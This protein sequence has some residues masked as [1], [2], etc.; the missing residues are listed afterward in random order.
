MVVIS[1][2]L[3]VGLASAQT[4]ITFVGWGNESRYHELFDADFKAFP[5]LGEKYEMRYVMAPQDTDAVAKL[6]LAL[7]SGVDIPDI[8][9]F[10][11]SRTIEFLQQGGIFADVT[12]YIE[13]YKDNVI[14]EVLKLVSYKDRYYGFPTQIKTKLWF[15]RKDLCD[16]A[17][18]D[19]SHVKTTDDFIAAGKKL[20]AKFPNAYIWNLGPQTAG[21]LPIEI[22]SG[23][24][25]R[26]SDEKGNYIVASDPGVRR[27]FVDLKRIVDSGVVSRINDWSP[28]WQK[29]FADG[30]LASQLCAK[31]LTDFLP[32]YAGK[33]QSGK[34]AVAQ[35]PAIGGADGGS[36][37]G[38]GLF[39][40]LD[41]SAN[42]AAAADITS[43]LWL[44]RESF[45]LIRKTPTFGAWSPILKDL[46]ADPKF[47]GNDYFGPSFAPQ[48]A[49]ALRKFKL[50]PYS[51]KFD[52]EIA[53]LIGYLD[54]YLNGAKSLDE[55]LSGAEKDM[56]NQLSNAFQS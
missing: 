33:D 56:K 10:N 32:G 51:P 52:Q 38:G 50:F 35:W 39:V 2:V 18:V 24:G 45:V 21:Y 25:A 54:Q 46:A 9:E 14:P 3:S 36:E 22:L 11:Y 20:R 12:S 19:P 26:F 31:W 42:K 7:V 41:K 13:P 43:K 8:M 29:G 53:I 15:Y 1:L 47:S 27:A 30:T 5:Q 55:A 28:D 23:N 48:A 34:W 6:R 4:R 49:E 16:A 37:A 40:V 17:G 44:T